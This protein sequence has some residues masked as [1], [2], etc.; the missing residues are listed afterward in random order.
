MVKTRFHYVLLSLLTI[1]FTISDVFHTIYLYSYL[2]IHLLSYSRQPGTDN[3]LTSIVILKIIMFVL[4]IIF[5][6]LIV[7]VY[8]QIDCQD[9]EHDSYNQNE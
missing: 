1:L 6:P 5:P 2:F 4:V 9:L 3:L 8:H 7:K